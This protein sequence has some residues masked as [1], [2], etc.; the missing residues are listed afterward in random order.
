MKFVVSAFF[1]YFYFN[2]TCENKKTQKFTIMT[3]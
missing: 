1:A 3:K 2:M